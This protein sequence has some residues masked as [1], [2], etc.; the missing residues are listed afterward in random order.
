VYFVLPSTNPE[1]VSK[2]SNGGLE[3][4]GKTPGIIVY[5]LTE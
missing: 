2:N 5:F 1:V 3:K 4:K